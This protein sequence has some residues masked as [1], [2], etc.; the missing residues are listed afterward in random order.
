MLSALGEERG[1]LGLSLAVQEALSEEG[2]V[3]LKSE[4]CTVFAPVRG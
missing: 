2:R 3:K 4:G 1:G